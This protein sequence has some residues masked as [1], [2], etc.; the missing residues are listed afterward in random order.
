MEFNLHAIP[1]SNKNKMQ[2]FSLSII[3]ILRVNCHNRTTFVHSITTEA[4][5]YN[6]VASIFINNDR[7]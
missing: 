2:N 1:R 6:V 3:A 4:L 5:A 7:K